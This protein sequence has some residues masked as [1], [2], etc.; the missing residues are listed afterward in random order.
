MTFSVEKIHG[1][2]QSWNPSGFLDMIEVDVRT[3][4]GNLRQRVTVR[5]AQ[6]EE[7]I[8][9]YNPRSE[10][11]ICDYGSCLTAHK[12]QGSS[13]KKVL[14]IEEV[15]RERWDWRRWC[16]TSASRAEKELAWV[17]Q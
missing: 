8:K 1:R 5:L 3:D 16:Y 15:W 13:Y 4:D 6:D 2:K 12:A 7:E 10:Y 9:D 14:V 11:I 17:R